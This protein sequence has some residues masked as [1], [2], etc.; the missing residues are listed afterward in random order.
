MKFFIRLILSAIFALAYGNAAPKKDITLEDILKTN[1]FSTQSITGLKSM[2]DGEHYTSLVNS[3]SQIVQYSYKTGETIDTLFSIVGIDGLRA[4]QDYEFSADESKILFYTNPER[5]Y[6]HSFFADYFLWDKQAEKLQKLT[7]KN[8]VRIASLSPDGS[9]AAF[10]FENNLYVKDLISGKEIQVTAD[11]Q[12]NKIQNGTPDWVYEE[13]FAFSRAYEWSPDG[14]MI[15]Y[16]RFDESM[17]ATFNMTRFKGTFPDLKENEIYPEN[18]TFKYPKA[19]EKNAIVSVHVYDLKKRKTRIMDIGAETDQYIPRIKWMPNSEKL[20]ILRLNRLQNHLEILLADPKNGKST[21]IYNDQETEYVDDRA[22]DSFTFVND[23]QFLIA[24]EKNEETHIILY[25]LKDGQIRNLTEKGHEVARFYGLDEK[26]RLVFYLAYGDNPC[27]NLIMA[28]DLEGNVSALIDHEGTNS[29]AFSHTF[30]YFINNF[31]NS[32]TPK[33][34]TLHDAKGNLIR[35]LEDNQA[36]KDSLENYNFATRDFFTFTTDE[37][38]ALHAWIQKP[39]DFD[40]AKKY[41]VLIDQYSGPGSQSVR[42]NWICDWYQSFN[43]KGYIVVAVDTRGTG[44]RGEKFKKIT[45]KQI[46]KYESDDL[47]ATAKYLQTLDFVDPDRIGIWGWSYGGY[48]TLLAMQKGQGIF[49][50]GVAVAPVTDYRFYDTIWTERYNSTPQLNPDG[51][52]ENS[53]LVTAKNL[54]GKL[55]IVHGTADDNVHAQNTYEYVEELVQANIQFDMMFYTNRNHS[56]YGG[57]TRYHLFTKIT[58][59]FLNN[60]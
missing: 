32:L 41:P 30:Q 44:G 48:T 19:G 14:K 22:F 39:V 28:A 46:G 37:N 8:K 43:A 25:S 4:I 54:K 42:N 12:T 51:Y 9:K 24:N 7:E 27:N 3:K 40:P 35:L 26:N 58:D 53:A 13:E 2:K 6:R 34:V 31:E 29:P 49:R 56:I 38:I 16:L 21:V 59:F 17:V 11:G 18:Y 60:L 5:L 33:R 10:V 57:N 23:E 50:A 15:A 47:V 20:A 45:Y 52:A 1:K 36:V 55:L